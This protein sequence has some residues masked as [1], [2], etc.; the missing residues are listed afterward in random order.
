MDKTHT[1]TECRFCT[2]MQNQSGPLE[3]DSP[4][5][6]NK[7]FSAFVS[8]GA[9]T[10]GWTLVLPQHHT[11]NMATEYARP[12]FWEFTA[13]VAAT[14]AKQYGPVAVFEHGTQA[15]TS[16]TGC[17]T[18]H[19]HLHIVPLSFSLSEAV[20][21]Y[22]SQ[23]SWT[24][25]KASDIERV[26]DGQEYLFAADRFDSERTEGLLCI[27]KE[28]TSQFFRRVIAA[29]LGLPELYDYKRFQMLDIAT[30]SYRQLKSSVSA[31]SLTQITV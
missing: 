28:P 20:A 23:L 18:G 27:L 25:C 7:N 9:L 1:A 12:D 10:Q 24:H 21:K 2:Y 13:Q 11:L 19:A 8:V 14:V 15:A 16:I 30:I 29:R 26:V 4:W 3:I 6:T 17:G 5:A 31:D 22:D